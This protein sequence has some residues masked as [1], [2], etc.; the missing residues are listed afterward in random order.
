MS[1][2]EQSIQQHDLEGNRVEQNGGKHG[3]LGD[4]VAAL[5]TTSPR[6]RAVL[7]VTILPLLVAFIWSY[8]PT[9]VEMV[10]QWD[11]QPDYS[12]GYFV[13]P[14]ALFLLWVRRDS[15][16][17]VAGRIAWGGLIP[18]FASLGLRWLGGY[19]YLG[20]ID[21][22]SIVFWC[23][24]VVWLFAGWRV[25]WWASPAV[26][27]LFFMIPLPFSAERMLSLPLQRVATLL[28]TGG[29]RFFGQPAL[30]EG[31][32]ILL[33]ET[34]LEVVQACSGLRIFVGILALA[35][36][37]IVIVR[38]PLW[39]K[40]VVALSVIP[41]TLIANST[42][43][44]VTGL[45]SQYFS[46][47]AAHTFT[48]DLAGWF[49]IPFAAGLFALVLWYLN[50]AFIAEEDVAPEALL[51]LPPGDHREAV[52]EAGHK[53][54]SHRSAVRAQAKAADVSVRSTR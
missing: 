37:Y 38:R 4:F 50:R 31:H 16:P 19:Y 32:T 36:A 28:S 11:T 26:V 6:Q 2:L 51:R 14:V 30:A 9:L 41:V 13:I 43:I 27:F 35:F 3:S 21:A 46:S 48:H 7:G 49:M 5:R 53:P 17:G 34:R 22:W 39:Q 10:R 18:L 52:L 23:A 24:G 8:W 25:L 1:T 40:A 15:F 47:D 12:H 42:R 29:L 44:V 54:A 45:L 20:S 33:G